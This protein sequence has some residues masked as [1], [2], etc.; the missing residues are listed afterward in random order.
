VAGGGTEEWFIT[1]DDLGIARAGLD[2]IAG[3]EPDDNAATVR[4]VFGGEPGP[5]RE[6]VAMNAGAAILAAGDAH[7]L[8]SGVERARET[9]DSG[10]AGGVLERLVR[11]TNELAA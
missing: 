9:I 10:A 8:G 11:L 7:D 4:A 6:V 3:A 2:A 5:A 1:P